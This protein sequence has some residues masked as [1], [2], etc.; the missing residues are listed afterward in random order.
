[1]DGQV[2]ETLEYKQKVQA[3][4]QSS[5]T[6]KARNLKTNRLLHYTFR[7]GESL[8]RADVI[9]KTVQFLY[10]DGRDFY[11]MDPKDFA[12]YSLKV[13]SLADKVAYLVEGQSVGLLLIEGQPATIELPKNVWL[14]VEAAEKAVKGDTSTSV[15]KEVRLSTGLIVKA[16]AFIKKG[17]VISVDTF[18]GT[19]RERQK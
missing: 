12:Q 18:Y 14:K 4:Q 11:F 3:R 19:Y 17:D 7:G 15:L 9:K 1:M 5:V 10:G 6:V 13:E 2:Y 8:A 16:P